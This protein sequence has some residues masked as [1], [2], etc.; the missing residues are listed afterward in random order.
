MAESLACKCSDDLCELLP[1]GRCLI[2]EL[3]K[4]VEKEQ[5]RVIENEDAELVKDRR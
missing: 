4:V 2:C 5:R 1:D 3:I